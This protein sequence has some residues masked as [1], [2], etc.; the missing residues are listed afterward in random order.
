MSP[1]VA[2]NQA[3]RTA[4]KVTW[5][6]GTKGGPTRSR[7]RPVTAAKGIA[8]GEAQDRPASMEIDTT[9]MP[10][11]ANSPLFTPSFFNV[12]PPVPEDAMEV[13]GIDSHPIPVTNVTPIPVTNV[14]P[15]SNA[16]RSSQPPDV[17]D[18]DV[19][20]FDAAPPPVPPPV[21]DY[22]ESLFDDD[23]AT[24]SRTTISPIVQPSHSDQTET[25]V[26]VSRVT[27]PP[28]S[29]MARSH[30]EPQPIP[31]ICI[32]S[33]SP[34]PTM[35][36]MASSAVDA[37]MPQTLPEASYDA[38]PT[39]ADSVDDAFHAVPSA[40]RSVARST[41]IG[42][43]PLLAVYRPRLFA[44]QPA[45]DLQYD[46]LKGIICDSENCESRRPII[47]YATKC[48]L[49]HDMRDFATRRAAVMRINGLDPAR[50]IN[51]ADQ[52]LKTAYTAYGT[53]LMQ[54][55]YRKQELEK[56]IEALADQ[57]DS[58]NQV[59]RLVSKQKGMPEP[60]PDGEETATCPSASEADME[61][62]E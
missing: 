39:P 22:A 4:R 15:I 10:G 59:A 43:L 25:M 45:P 35:P 41:D 5:A 42:D 58:T 18:F 56:E 61:I 44:P 52:Y 21:P 34:P 38:L 29:T 47:S 12:A 31:E 60:R 19:S 17:P 33:P 16:W 26:S 49:D 20:F 46:C 62:V 36:S 6:E 28:S 55:A 48:N 9:S 23:A 30:G 3:N 40:S 14:T 13:F 1:A 37:P 8:L 24:I 27:S 51:E 2:R 57:L 50:Y 53:R 11:V 54:L 7:K 32:L